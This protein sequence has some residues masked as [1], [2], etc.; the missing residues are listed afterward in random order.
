MGRGLWQNRAPCENNW[1]ERF[2]RIMPYGIITRVFINCMQCGNYMYL[3]IQRFTDF[4]VPHLLTTHTIERSVINET[5]AVA[6][7]RDERGEWL[8]SPTAHPLQPAGAPR[9]AYQENV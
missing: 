1:R 6:R 5:S 9:M 7:C 4:L 3:S 8:T 2:Q